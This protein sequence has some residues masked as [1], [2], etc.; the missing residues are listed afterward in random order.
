[1]AD[2]VGTGHRLFLVGRTPVPECWSEGPPPFKSVS[3]HDR[4]AVRR[5]A[6]GR[7]KRRILWGLGAG[8]SGVAGGLGLAAA[9]RNGHVR[10][11]SDVLFARA[12]ADPAVA[13][14]KAGRRGRVSLRGG[15]RRR[16]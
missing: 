2:R 7:R 13:L 5:S 1:V 16:D 4:H 14:A 15:R 3:L 12:S 8:G 11:R 10:L 6:V 9:K